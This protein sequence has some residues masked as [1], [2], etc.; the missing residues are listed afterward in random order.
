MGLLVFT[1]AFASTAPRAALSVHRSPGCLVL[2]AADAL[3]FTRAPTGIR[4]AAHMPP[5]P[6]QSLAGWQGADRTRRLVGIRALSLSRR[7]RR[8]PV[9]PRGRLTGTSTSFPRS[10]RRRHLS[11]SS[12]LH[13]MPRSVCARSCPPGGRNCTRKALEIV[14]VQCHGD[15]GSTGKSTVRGP[16]AYAQPLRHTRKRISALV[17]A[18]IACMAD[19]GNEVMA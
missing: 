12:P 16:A 1:D 5:S 6:V 10:C 7:H 13:W 19:L 14:A 15:A 3:E 2:H 18:A 9:A 11:T 8:A 17:Y 4:A